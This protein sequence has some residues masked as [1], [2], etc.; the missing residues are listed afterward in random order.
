MKTPAVNITN[1]LNDLASLLK[2]KMQN[3]K[4]FL[5]TDESVHLHCLGLLIESIGV[6]HGIEIIEVED[7][8]NSKSIEIFHHICEHLAELEAGKDDLLICLGGGMV[9][10]LGGFIGATYKRGIAYV[11][12]PTSLLAMID[13]A[14]GGKN[15]LNLGPIKNAVGT[16]ANPEAVFIYPPFL[17]TL[18]EIELRSGFAEVIKH[19]IISGGNFWKKITEIEELTPESLIPL[20]PDAYKV[21]ETI[22]S[23]DLFE[24]GPRKKLNLGHTIGHA[25]ESH[26]LTENDVITHGEAVA[27]GIICETLISRKRETLSANDAITIIDIVQRWFDVESYFLPEYNH[28]RKFLY[29]DKKNINHELRLV[30]PFAI[31]SVEYNIQV[32]EE[33]VRNC[34][35]H[36]RNFE[37]KENTSIAHYLV[38]TM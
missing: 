15:G 7:G 25:L 14:N 28:I 22:T 36:F 19:G 1:R 2:E 11:H 33:T 5:L 10:D 24:K 23:E 12:V 4:T 6:D 9:T 21:K 34:Y 35:E 20:I 38:S 27:L 18:P 29:Q 30:L 13:A 17:Q 8:E 26:Y 16:I 37:R 31:G 3:R 32:E